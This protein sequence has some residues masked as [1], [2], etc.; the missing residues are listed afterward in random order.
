MPGSPVEVVWK[1][2]LA[3]HGPTL[4]LAKAQSFVKTSGIAVSPHDVVAHHKSFVRSNG[5]LCDVFSPSGNR[6][7]V[8]VGDTLVQAPKLRL[9]EGVFAE[10]EILP[11]SFITK[12]RGHPISADVFYEINSNE[13]GQ[14]RDC[15]EIVHVPDY[16]HDE[17][18]FL[19]GRVWSNNDLLHFF[20]DHAVASL[21]RIGDNSNAAMVHLSPDTI[22]LRATRRIPPGAEIVRSRLVDPAVPFPE[23]NFGPQPRVPEVLEPPPVVHHLHDEDDMNARPAGGKTVKVGRKEFPLPAIEVTSFGM[24]AKEPMRRGTLVAL[25]GG[26]VMISDVDIPFNDRENW[27]GLSSSGP[28]ING[29]IDSEYTLQFYIAVGF[30][31][32]LCATSQQRGQFNC[33]FK[34]Q[35][36][37][38][39]GIPQ[40]DNTLAPTSRLLTLYTVRDIAAGEEL[41]VEF[42][43][44]QSGKVHVGF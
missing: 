9:N 43:P 29:S 35:N 38:N 28:Y 21:C 31:A 32:S 26:K 25:Y 11:G 8:L 3:V 39:G 18:V 22:Y 37:S 27:I 17:T 10:E 16:G 20:S 5:K 14:S 2:A 7:S 41:R 1:V 24:L 44:P 23:F 36:V 15:V 13:W 33:K 34:A 4:T 40:A 12:F 42:H 19:D 6:T 30:T